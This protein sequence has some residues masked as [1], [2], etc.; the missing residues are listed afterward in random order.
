MNR[1]DAVVNDC[2]ISFLVPGIDPSMV[3]VRS[4]GSVLSGSSLR[5]GGRHRSRLG[6]RSRHGTPLRTGP[7]PSFGVTD[8]VWMLVWILSLWTCVVTTVL[9][10]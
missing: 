5:S 6:N 7:W 3:L 8:M 9:G 4:D 10:S 1:G 2:G